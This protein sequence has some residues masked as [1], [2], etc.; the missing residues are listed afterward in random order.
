MEKERLTIS[1]QWG[2][3]SISYIE[4]ESTKDMVQRFNTALES[5]NSPL[6]VEAANKKQ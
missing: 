5:I 4:G 2:S 6:R 1:G 3:V